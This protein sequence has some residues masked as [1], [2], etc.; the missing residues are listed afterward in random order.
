MFDKKINTMN[1]ASKELQQMNDLILYLPDN[2]PDK[3]VDILLVTGDAYIDHPSFGIAVIAR[4]LESKGYSVCI[5]SQ[6]PYYD[7]GYLDL[8]PEPRLFIG[9]SSGNLD[10]VV[11][12]YS[13]SRVPR[14]D[15]SYSIGGI[16]FFGNGKRRR[17]DR[18]LVVYSNY[19]R[20]RFKNVPIVIG[21][22]EASIRRFAHYDFVQQKLKKSV[23]IDAKADILVYSMGENAVCEIAGRIAGSTPLYGING[24]AVRMSRTEMEGDAGSGRG[25][26][27][28]PS[29]D[30]MLTERPLLIE[31]TRIVESNMI[32]DKSLELVQDNG[33]MFVLAFPPQ[34]PLTGAQ[35]DAVYSLPFRKDYPEYCKDVPAWNMIKDS[36]TSH[37]G[38]YGKCSFCAIFI[39]QGPVISQRSE[40]S[41][42]KESEDLK[43]K[44]FFRKTITD[45]GGPTANMYGTHCSIGW[46]DDPHCLFPDVCPNLSIDQES[47]MKLISAVKKLS[48][49]RNVFVSSGIRHDLALLKKSETEFIITECT[50]GHLKMAPE[51]IDEKILRLMRKPGNEVFV[52]F[53]EFFNEVK[54]RNELGFFMLPYIILSFPGSEEKSVVNLG[55]FLCQNDISTHQYQDF[56]PVPGTMATAF[57]YAGQDAEGNKLETVS[58]SGGRS[59]QRELLKNIL[60]KKRDKK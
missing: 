25:R 16:G 50:S 37:R 55:N 9:I 10:S 24:T 47:Y 33:G 49:I 28:L 17:P 6:P 54:S 1:N 48:G 57:Y 51:H 36:I 39:H 13:A 46:C 34:K 23:L 41:V 52:R 15:D 58:A 45:I 27:R 43:D 19:V 18:A 32:H 7:P 3:N 40:T 59:S 22:L 29:F 5:V 38:C 31:A 35:I 2:K 8:L 12:N 21:G 42:V 20:Q 44:P 53:I 60:M 26:I 14:K 4:L 56:T 11:S 30:E